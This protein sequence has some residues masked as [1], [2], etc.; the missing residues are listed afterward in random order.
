MVGQQIKR[1]QQQQR[2]RIAD[3]IKTEE[4]IPIAGV[5]LE[6]IGGEGGPESERADIE[7]GEAPGPEG[8]TEMS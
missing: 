7:M 8:D 5:S 2:G 4:E 1:I 3:G 6:G